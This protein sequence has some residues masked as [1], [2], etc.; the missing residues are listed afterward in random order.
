MDAVRA[1]ALDLTQ[2]EPVC[3]P[4]AFTCALDAAASRPLRLFA[5]VVLSRDETCA[6]FILMILIMCDVGLGDVARLFDWHNIASVR[7]IGWCRW[8]CNWLFLRDFLGSCTVR[9]VLSATALSRERCA[10]GSSAGR[11]LRHSVRRVA[12]ALC[13]AARARLHAKNKRKKRK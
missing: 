1:S 7:T 5:I 9:G 4:G 3:D 8:Y 12:C 6:R 13:T 10:G 2:A 11:T